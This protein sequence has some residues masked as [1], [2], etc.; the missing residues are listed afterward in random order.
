MAK[1]QTTNK[2][3]PASASKKKQL[4]LWHHIGLSLTSTAPVS[5]TGKKAAHKHTSHGF[6]L[7][8]LILTGALLFSN[9]GV[10]HAYAATSAGSV[11]VSA[12]VSGAPPTVGA[13]IT[14]PA[15]NT[16]TANKYV[17]V[18][19]ICPEQTLVAIYRNGHFAG[20]ALCSGGEFVVTT[21]LV[22][23]TNV[24]QAQNYDGLNQPGPTTPQVIITYNEPITPPTTPAADTA[25]N[26][27]QTPLNPTPVT[28]TPV[29]PQPS[30]NPCFTL[31]TQSDRQSNGPLIQVGCVHRNIY[32]GETLGLPVSLT[33]GIAPYALAANW[34]D[35][36]QDLV[37]V[38][39]NESRTLSHT[40]TASG[41][42]QIVLNATD[43]NGLTA[44][45]QTVV[46]VDGDPT[47]AP[48]SGIEKIINTAQAIWVNAPVPLYVAVVTLAIGFWVGDI[49]QR[50]NLARTKTSGSHRKQL[51]KA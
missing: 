44:R 8:A 21:Q 23:G 39:N 27:T 24:L 9:L 2:K 43:S 30:E 16:T 13:E 38:T 45:T 49:F 33:G 7:S 20:S 42:Y 6:L 12:N 41:Y 32:I 15:T 40:Y 14:F 46:S 51:R 28:P 22:A 35:N 50:V 37:A 36:K 29:A 47:V 10:L 31:T 4:S 17:E 34:G 25:T 3:T 19:G 48:V 1:K 18:K 5:H 26:S 11:T